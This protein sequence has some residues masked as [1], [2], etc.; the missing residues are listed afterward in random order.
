MLNSETPLKHCET[1]FPHFSRKTYG[2]VQQKQRGN[3]GLRRRQSTCVARVSYD[4]L[5]RVIE[6]HAQDVRAV[7]VLTAQS[8]GSGIRAIDRCVLNEQMRIAD[9]ERVLLGKA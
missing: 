6:L 4:Q 7:L 3:T 1:D 9:I 8:A 5:K 2:A